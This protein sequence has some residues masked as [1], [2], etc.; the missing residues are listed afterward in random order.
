[1]KAQDLHSVVFNN[2]H[3][4]SVAMSGGYSAFLG[5]ISSLSLVLM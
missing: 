5:M 3:G 1:M 4:I 2:L